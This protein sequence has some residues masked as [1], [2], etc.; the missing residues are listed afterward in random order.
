MRIVFVGASDVTLR[1]AEL[2]IKR[3]NEVIIV[4]SDQELVENISEDM[5]CSFLNGDGSN[6]AVLKETD[7]E[8]CDALFCLTDSDQINL[9]SSLVGRSLGFPKVVTRIDGPEF[10]EICRELGLSDTIMPAQTIARYLADMIGGVDV[11]ELST[12]IKDKARFFSFTAS[13]EDKGTA[14]ELGLPEGARVVC[15]YRD[16]KFMLADEDTQIKKGDE[17]IVLTYAENLNELNERWYPQSAASENGEDEQ[18]E[19]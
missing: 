11:L 10:V 5:D 3:G 19:D 9:I 17:V 16:D 4:E 13:P 15:L 12:I 1:T 8:S 14:G 18:E 6:P 2:L 7:P